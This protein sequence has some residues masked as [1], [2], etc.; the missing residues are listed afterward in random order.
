MATVTNTRDV[1]LRV[2]SPRYVSDTYQS[3]IDVINSTL[4]DIAS[5]TKITA[6]ERQALRKEWDQIIA[7]YV[8]NST[9]GL[10]N[11]D[12][13]YTAVGSFYTA[14][15]A[16]VQALGTYL[17]NGT[18][19]TL[20]ALGSSPTD[21]PNW[22]SN[23]NLTS[24]AAQ[25]IVAATFRNNWKAVYAAETLLVNKA[26]DEAGK[27]AGWGG[28]T[29]A[30][31]PADYATADIALVNVANCTITGNSFVK[32]S[33]SSTNWDASVRTNYGY[34]NCAYVEAT[35]PSV[36]SAMIGF[37]TTASSSSAYAEIY[38]ALWVDTNNYITIYHRGGLI[39]NN[40]VTYSAGDRVAVLVDD[41]FATFFKNG[42][43]I[44]RMPRV[45]SYNETWYLD[46]SVYTVGKGLSNVKFNQ[47][48]SNS[49]KGTN[50]LDCSGWEVDAAD[51]QEGGWI[52]A[53]DAYNTNYIRWNTGPDGSQVKTW[54]GYALDNTAGEYSGGILESPR[55]PIDTTKKYRYSVWVMKVG[56][57][58]N[59]GN[60]HLG[61]ATDS[62]VNY[63]VADGGGAHTNP[64]VCIFNRN[65]MTYGKWYL[66]VGYIFPAGYTGA[67]TLEGGAFLGETGASVTSYKLDLRWSGTQTS[68]FMRV[69]DYGAATN[70]ASMLIF[71][72]R[73]DIC[74]G[75]EPSVA[76][77]LAM[78]SVSGRN[79][80]TSSNTLSYL[81]GGAITQPARTN[82]ADTYLYNSSAIAS[83]T[84]Y[85]SGSNITTISSS[86]RIFAS[87]TGRVLVTL[88][89]T[90]S[91]YLTCW[92][93]LQLVDTSSGTVVDETG[94]IGS[95][96][97]AVVD[98][99]LSNSWALFP[100]SIA[101]L[102][103]AVTVDQYT[104]RLYVNISCH[105]GGNIESNIIQIAHYGEFSVVE[106]KA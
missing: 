77:L 16:A 68:N 14:Y 100:V 93:K 82:N 50:L 105:S 69:F 59:T 78:G 49:R 45:Q 51:D 40:L 44:Y 106:L 74:D 92:L 47:V 84:G 81:S 58:S 31:K 26:T 76:E 24:T 94:L 27:V 62:S 65:Q 2:A 71:A 42:S 9:T 67:P 38:Y 33:G 22:I 96:S 37:N 70:N 46:T 101:L 35:V 57:D 54:R 5:D 86:S 41:Y 91:R 89:T 98:N 48:T 53:S 29:G 20:P 103:D 61:C 28:V 80:I 6:A 21:A 32:T 63:L 12:N 1:I 90:S 83:T 102:F 3:Q 104:P 64:Y 60:A 87:T 56:T 10:A 75:S 34:N 72:P 52:A 25:T 4:A 30:G 19:Y 99:T 36:C 55:V 39:V 13:L 15:V 17:N 8:D 88:N 7:K 66:L 73:I 79:K 85:R 43:V 18:T 11:L 23:A 97:L 95:S